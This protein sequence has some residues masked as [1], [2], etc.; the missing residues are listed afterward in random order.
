MAL[1]F[2]TASCIYTD[3]S[4][5]YQRSG[6]IPRV[7][8]PDGVNSTPLEP[9]YPIP[10]VTQRMD[11]FLESDIGGDG[12][13]RPEPM[14]AER[15]AAKIKIQKVGDRQWMLVEAPASQ[16]WPLAQSYLSQTGIEVA[17][18]DAEVGLIET[19]WVQFKLDN[20]NQSRFQIRIEKGVRYETTEVHILQD[21]API[22]TNV[23]RNWPAKSIDE[24]RETWLLEG[25][26]NT[27]VQSIGNKAAS[28]LGQ[29]V[30]GDS[31]AELV[32]HE[33]EPALYLRLNK[34]RAWATLAHGLKSDGFIKWE[35]NDD[36]GVFYF[37]FTGAYKRPNWFVRLFTWGDDAPVKDAPYSMNEVLQHLAN[38]SEVKSLVSGI[39]PVAFN[40]PLPNSE[41]Y[42]LVLS[43]LDGKWV[44]RVRDYKGERLD[45]ELNK[46]LLAMLRRNLI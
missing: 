40:E 27:L 10:P 44:A 24:E 14:S 11:A 31:K 6:S 8:L 38:N 5:D 29:S 28:L 32:L 36:L 4:N 39:T 18:S 7:T 1:C 42:L 3:R 23:A 25:M 2:S 21:Q 20:Q 15:E 16:V 12:V 33:E 41:G 43:H 17:K 35:E 37:Q 26:A 9:L 30:G 22:N 46:K 34:V 45:L 13:P 19:Q